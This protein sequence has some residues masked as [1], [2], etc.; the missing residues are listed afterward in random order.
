M[1]SGGRIT[2]EISQEVSDAVATT[3]SNI[4]SP[5]VTNRNA[6]SVVTTQSG[7]TLVFG[8]L[9]QTTRSFGTAGVPL[10]SKIPVIGGLFGTQSLKD[11]TTELVLLITP[12]LV[13]DVAQARD[14]LEEIR[15]KMPAL[16]FAMPPRKGP[17]PAPR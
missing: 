14:A 4:D 10:L 7:E 9:I 1:N 3:S 13:A 11:Q 5:T 16:E 17:E 6:Q 8:G 2:L 12:K 15:R